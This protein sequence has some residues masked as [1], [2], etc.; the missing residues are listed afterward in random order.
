MDIYL[1][2]GNYGVRIDT[3]ILEALAF[4]QIL[5]FLD[6][7]NPGLKGIFQVEAGITENLVPEDCVYGK[8]RC[9]KDDCLSCAKK[10]IAHT[11]K[12]WKYWSE[13]VETPDRSLLVFT[14]NLHM[15]DMGKRVRKVGAMEAASILW[16][17]K[18]ATNG[19]GKRIEENENI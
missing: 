2:A 7:E 14:P 3:E 16:G 9:R 13:T 17:E 15:L 19:T 8:K 5:Q 4:L 1:Y 10:K 18:G 12:K 11:S 6:A